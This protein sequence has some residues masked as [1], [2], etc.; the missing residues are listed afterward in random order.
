MVE[1]NFIR[2]VVFDFPKDRIPTTVKGNNR[3]V[4]VS[5]NED[6]EVANF[7]FAFD[8]NAV[9]SESLSEFLNSVNNVTQRLFGRCENVNNT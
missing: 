3:N 6:K 5:H 4:S 7:V 9:F 8:V 1:Y 2:L